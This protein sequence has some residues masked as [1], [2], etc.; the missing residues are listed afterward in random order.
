MD[1]WRRLLHRWFVEHNPLYLLSAALVLGGMFL[2]SQGLAESGR[3]VGQLGVAAIA[4]VYALAL[5]GGAAFL[6]RIGWRRSAVMLAG[7]AI[8]YQGD[9]TLHTETC[10][11]LG[12]VGAWAAGAWLVLFV[13][14]LRALAWAVRIR[15]ARGTFAT[16]I[17]G[18]AGLAFFPFLSHLPPAAIAPLVTSWLAVIVFSYRPDAVT[19]LVDLD[20]WGATVL[21]RATRASWL[22]LALL[23]LLHLAFRLPPRP[24]SALP[25]VL[26]L[27]ILST[28]WIR[29][30]LRVWSVVVMTLAFSARHHP[31][32]FAALAL[33]A[34]MALAWRA[35]TAAHAD[36]EVAVPSPETAYRTSDAELRQPAATVTEV[37]P[38]G[39]DATL[40]LAAGSLSSLYLGLWT[41]RW[42]GGPWPGHLVA[43][44]VALGAIVLFAVARYRARVAL[45]P[46]AATT[47]HFVVA[48]RL[49]S[50][51]D[52][53]LGWGALA[54]TLGFV[55]LGGSLTVSYRL[56]ARP[57]VHE[58]AP[59]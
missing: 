18:A 30:E 4:E 37:F 59:P 9:L 20:A 31:A 3:L 14:K 47:V 49:V 46:L 45:V 26:V 35:W 24:G 32:S 38:A 41:L 43:L 33:V 19:S 11:H 34:A 57:A 55:L 22:V 29:S 40:R 58:S 25:L 53:M 8:V 23:L 28:R 16:T 21:R 27:P 5:I 7:L 50:L 15:I 17:L 10:A 52:T 48:S 56:R 1:W 13:V 51:P 44:D 42:S 6:T 36:V 2:L 39:R 54:T 12:A